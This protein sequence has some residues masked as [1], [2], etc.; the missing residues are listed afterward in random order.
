M[1]RALV[2]LVLALALATGACQAQ[3]AG[4]ADDHAARDR[5]TSDELARVIGAL[6][7]A[8]R[9]AISVRTPWRDPLAPA[10]AAAG[11]TATIAIA[12][13]P[14]ADA[15][16]L[17]RDARQLIASAVP[18]AAIAIA[19]RPLA[20]APTL[21]SVGPFDVATGSRGPLI[22]TLALAL[23]AIAGLAIW[24]VVLDARQRR[25]GISAQ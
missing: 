9:V 4:P 19:V 12:A 22:A 1:T 20:P 10:A 6:P 18:G 24:I 14:G 11:A 17:E 21:T 2:P 5:A 13:D 3:I 16:A 23:I 15:A 25:R 7:G 8:A